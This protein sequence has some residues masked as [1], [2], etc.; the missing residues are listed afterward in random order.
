MT[1]LIPASAASYINAELGPDPDYVWI[2]VSW[3]LGAAVLVSVGGRLSDIF[4][5]RY[6][7]LCGAFIA[8]IGTIVGATGRSIGQMIASGVLFGIG[9]GF[10]EMGFACI[11]EFIPNKYR[12]TALGLYGTSGI[13]C[14]MSPLITYAFIAHASIGWRGAYWFMCAIHGCAGIFLFCFYHPPT[15]ETKHKEGRVSRWKLVAEMDYIGLFLFIAGCTLFLVGLN[16]GGRQYPWMSSA[17]IGPI[18][19]GFMLLVL[20]F[21]WDFNANL[22]YPL[23]P[24]KLFRQWR[25]YNLLVLVG[26]CC[27]M[28]YYSMQVLWPRQSGLLFVPADDPIMRGVYANLTTWGTWISLISVWLI[29]ARFGHEK[30][31]ILIFICCQVAFVGGLSSVGVSDKAKAIVLVFLMSCV[32]NQPLY[33]LF[34]M[35]SLNIEDQ[36]DMGIAIGAL[37]TFRLLGGAVAT[38]IYSSI[39]DNQFKENL[40]GKITDAIAGTGFD[41][42]NLTA[43]IQAAAANTATAYAKVPGITAQIISVSQ[44]AVKLAYMQAYRVVYYTA[45][46]FAV[47]AIVSATLVPNVDPAKKTMEKAVLLENEKTRTIVVETEKKAEDAIEKV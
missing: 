26:F 17:V 36:A 38:A 41:S 12:L 16:F 47:L 15:F 5:R 33:M 10:Q 31:Q 42:S 18:V 13:F 43:L 25:R 1:L 27:G 23:L 2:N 44:F 7:M 45:L 37:S 14:L 8:F 21:V 28:L 20:L 29:C 32:I 30:W 19:V 46:G 3:G 4:G 34:N 39:V 40:P 35:V 24:P 9:S 6:F 22:K 11:M